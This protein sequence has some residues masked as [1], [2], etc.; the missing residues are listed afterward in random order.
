MRSSNRRLIIRHDRNVPSFDHPLKP[1]DTL[2][3][4]VVDNDDAITGILQKSW[5]WRKVRLLLA[6]L[7]RLLERFFA[8]EVKVQAEAS[9]VLVSLFGE[10]DRRARGF[11]RSKRGPNRW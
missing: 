3:Y 2:G 11:I 4:H 7:H 5:L 1:L 6:S 9:R 8:S 10:R